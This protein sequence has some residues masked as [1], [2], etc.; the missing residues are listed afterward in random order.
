MYANDL[1]VICRAQLTLIAHGK[2]IGLQGNYIQKD[3]QG[4]WSSQVITWCE[5]ATFGL[6]GHLVLRSMLRKLV[7]PQGVHGFS[8]H[9]LIPRVSR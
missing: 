8:L 6:G 9:S 2:L 4:R 5:N 7:K 3:M 1:T